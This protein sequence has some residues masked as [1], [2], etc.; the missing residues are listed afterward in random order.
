MYEIYLIYLILNCKF[1]CFFNIEDDVLSN[2][3]LN[4]NESR[5]FLNV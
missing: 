3:I 4:D 1:F 2:L 5:W